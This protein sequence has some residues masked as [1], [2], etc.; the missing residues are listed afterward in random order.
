MLEIYVDK[1]EVLRVE[2]I[3]EGKTVQQ[4][5]AENNVGFNPRGG[6]IV[7]VDGSRSNPDAICRSNV[8]FIDIQTTAYQ[9]KILSKS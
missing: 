6:D 4:V 8:K 7:Y 3:G 5:L 9:E 2:E 1:G